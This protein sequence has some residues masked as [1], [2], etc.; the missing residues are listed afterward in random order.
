MDLGGCV[1][2]E[3]HQWRADRRPRDALAR[4]L[5]VAEWDHAGVIANP[6]SYRGN[7]WRFFVVQALIH[8]LLWIPIWVVFLQ[9]KGLSLT[10]I[11]V[12]ESVAWVLAAAIEVP[13]GAIADRWGRKASMALG[14]SL[15]ALA[16]FLILTEALSPTFLLGYALW[17]TS[18]AFISGADT[19]FLY[20]SLKADGRAEEAAKQSGR[21]LAITQGSQG[22]ASVI[23]AAVATLDITLCFT[24]GGVSGL[25]A[26]AL[27]LTF[28]EPPR[29]EAGETP[30]SFWRN[31]RV[32]VAIALR[33]PAVRW[34]LLLTAGFAI[35][36]LVV[37]YVLLQPYALAVGLPIASLGFVV[38][39]VQFAGVAASW[40]AHRIEGRVGLWTLVTGGIAIS[41]GAMSLLG[42]LPSVPTV[43]L[44]LAVALVPALAQPLL[45][46]HLNDL[47]PSAQ[48]ATI[49]SLSA[50]L[51]ELGLA[52]AMPLL[53]GLADAFG[54]PATM[55]ISA[56]VYALTVI[57]FAVLWR[58]AES[59]R[60]ALTRRS[61]TG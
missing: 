33:R 36:P 29:L 28:K 16:M 24:I 23:G 6:R 1:G 19:A 52:F 35:V 31:L 44:V 56:P 10:Q 49:I 50:L 41:I 12:L 46:A 45:S 37:Y 55:G 54:A 20:D 42:A 21:Y 22:V 60:S 11:G 3:P 48:R 58:F 34:L 57:P 13:T 53:L 30:L 51:F 47:I 8:F 17:N 18:F 43:A 9:Q 39:G 27:V 4:R 15:Y 2:V 32:A 38:L 14:T 7:I 59:S 25:V 61:R 26:T 5:D 40:L